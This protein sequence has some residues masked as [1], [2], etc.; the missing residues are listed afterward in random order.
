MSNSFTLIR[1]TDQKAGPVALQQI[2][3]E[4]REHL[5][6]VADPKKSYHQW[7]DTIGMSLAGGYSLEIIVKDCKEAIQEHSRLN[8]PDGSRYWETKLKIA[9]YLNEHFITEARA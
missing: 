7:V 3:N 5:G 6:I 1:K 8:N 4:I 2:D 9:Q